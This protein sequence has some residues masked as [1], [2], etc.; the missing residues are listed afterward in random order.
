[1]VAI[2]YTYE[3]DGEIVVVP[4]GSKAIGK[5]QQAN[6][7][8]CLAAFR[9][10]GASDGTTEKTNGGAM[11]LDFAPVRGVVT[12]QKRGVRLLVQT[13]MAWA[14]PPRLLGWPQVEPP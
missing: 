9:H 3:R 2:E 1:M 8:V 12:G 5:P 6:C 4:A 11:G 13:L 14:R 7:C 10:A